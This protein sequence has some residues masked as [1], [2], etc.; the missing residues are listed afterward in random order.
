MDTLSF[1]TKVGI[2]SVEF[3]S[4]PINHRNVKFLDSRF[5]GND[6]GEGLL[7]RINPCSFS[8]LDSRFCGNDGERV[9]V[10][11]KSL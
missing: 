1:P 7:F 2:Q 4:F 9:V 11:D 3:Q 5:R 6:G 8:F 10:S